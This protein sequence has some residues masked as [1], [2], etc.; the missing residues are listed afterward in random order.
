MMQKLVEHEIDCKAEENMTDRK[1]NKKNGKKEWRANKNRKGKVSK[2]KGI[3]LLI[4]LILIL[5]FYFGVSLYFQNHFIFHTVIAG[6]D[7]SGK[8]AWEVEREIESKIASYQLVLEEREGKNESIFAD[9]IDLCF[10][11]N[12][13]IEELLEEQN[14]FDWLR[15]FF[16]PET[17]EITTSVEYDESLLLERIER[18]ECLD[19]NNITDPVDAF[20]QYS[21]GEY[22]IVD[23]VYGNRVEKEILITLIKEAIANGV[24]R[25]SLEEEDCYENPTYSSSSEEL[26][27]LKDTLNQYLAAEITYDFGDRTEVVDR[28]MI[29]EWLSYDDNLQIVFN[30]EEIEKFIEMCIRDRLW[31][32]EGGTAYFL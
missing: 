24:S 18:L 17:Y 8:T 3:L 4:P 25:I 22:R 12:G 27:E 13:E 16:E 9:E 11:S 29:Q 31:N 1:K 28:A 32:H 15:A 26:I 21:E 2:N 7:C 14:P 5:V 6:I 20:V 19:E 30:E 10:I 23:E